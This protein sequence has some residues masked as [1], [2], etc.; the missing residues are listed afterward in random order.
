MRSEKEILLM[1]RK[2]TDPLFADIKLKI[3]SICSFTVNQFDDCHGLIHDIPF[4]LTNLN[5]KFHFASP[6]I[7]A[8][9]NVVSSIGVD[10]AVDYHDE[11]PDRFK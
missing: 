10:M 1:M 5:S 4:L 8:L 9:V 6:V 2:N 7:T 3:D 11:D